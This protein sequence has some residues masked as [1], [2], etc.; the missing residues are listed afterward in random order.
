MCQ[1]DLIEVRKPS[2]NHRTNEAWIGHAE[3]DSAQYADSGPGQKVRKIGVLWP[4]ASIHFMDTLNLVV[5]YF[6]LDIL[7]RLFSFDPQDVLHCSA[8]HEIAFANA[9]KLPCWTIFGR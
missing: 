7:P 2:E 4:K 9:V 5:A 3:I 1:H 6:T 8:K